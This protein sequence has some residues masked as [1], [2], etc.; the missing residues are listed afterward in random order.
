MATLRK[1]S[2]TGLKAA[3]E[4]FAHNIRELISCGLLIADVSPFRGPHADDETA[5]E[6]GALHKPIFAYTDD[7][8]TLR[9]RIIGREKSARISLRDVNDLEIEN[10]GKRT[11]R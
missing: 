4:I 6:M 10:L 2:A 8:R 9:Q 1:P 5:F 3:R 7:T 11:I